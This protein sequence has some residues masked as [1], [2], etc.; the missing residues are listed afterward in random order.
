MAAL[1]LFLPL[2]R[3]RL[4][5][6]PETVLHDAIRDAC[7]EF[8]KRTQLL[9]QDVTVDVVEDEA[10]TE[11]YP[12][13][14]VVWDILQV[15]RDTT[16]LT[17]VNRTE[18]LVHGYNTARGDPAYYYCDG[19]RV[20]VLGPVPAASETLMAVV[21]LR[22]TDTSLQVPDVLWA[23][24]REPISAGARA[25]VRRHYGEWS[26]PRLEAEDRQFFERAVHNQNIRRAR[27]GAG[28]TLRVR[29]HTF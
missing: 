12:D 20:L 24:Y 25:W 22:P 14:D 27:G 15:R 4:P 11:L 17:A 21:T 23:D 6:C 19:D 18:F 28:V 3:G 26:E 13:S 5:G 8:C 9:T 29:A 16:P 1:T 10:R 7:I 2:I